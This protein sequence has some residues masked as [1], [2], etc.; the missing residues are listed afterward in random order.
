[1]LRPPGEFDHSY[2]SDMAT[3]RRPW[4]WGLLVLFVVS[5][6]VLPQ[7]ASQ[8]ITSL[9]NRIF[10]SIIAVQG[11]NLLTG[12]TGQISIGQAAFMTVGGYISALLVNKLGF[13][14][15]VALPFAALGS[16]LI[17]LLFGLPSLRKHI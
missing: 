11:L 4:Q 13:S 17:G 16:G 3:I 7:V 10:I 9:A 12:Y 1:M 15:F 5:L 2:G 6:Y 8:S 14:F